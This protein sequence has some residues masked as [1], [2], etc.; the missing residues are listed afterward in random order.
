MARD[1][2]SWWVRQGYS[3]DHPLFSRDDEGQPDSVSQAEMADGAEPVIPITVMTNTSDPSRPRTRGAGYDPQT[4]TL[5]IQFREG[6]IYHYHDVQPNEWK[7]LRRVISAGKFIN[8]R[9]A[10][11]D[12]IRVSG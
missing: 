12:Y 9:L 11:K 7:D 2:D 5:A 10:S 1:K 4:R 6:A 3:P 8:R